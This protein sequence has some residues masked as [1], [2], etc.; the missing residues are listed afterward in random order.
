[1]HVVFDEAKL[2]YTVNYIQVHFASMKSNEWQ[3]RASS[4]PYAMGKAYCKL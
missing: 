3:G 1:M 4:Q 2:A